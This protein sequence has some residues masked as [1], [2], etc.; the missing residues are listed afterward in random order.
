MSALLALLQEHTVTL[1]PRHKLRGIVRENLDAVILSGGHGF[2]VMSHP[3]HFSEELDFIRAYEQPLIGICL[4]AEL[5]V[6]AFG[7]Q[8]VRMPQ[9]RNGTMRIS[10]THEETM[11]ANFSVSEAHEWAIPALPDGLIC[12]AQSQDGCELFRSADR[13]IVG[14]QFHPELSGAAV[15]SYFLDE[16]LPK[17]RADRLVDSNMHSLS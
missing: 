7:G 2:S 9:R 13:R 15:Q 1:F 3:E 14:M 16:I 5:I 8:L 11:P 10:L 4:G 6:A 12:I 17:K